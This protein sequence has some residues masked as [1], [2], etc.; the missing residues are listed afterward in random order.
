MES[1]L[2]LIMA[3]AE[4]WEK[5]SFSNRTSRTHFLILMA[6]HNLHREENKDLKK[7]HNSLDPKRRRRHLEIMGQGVPEDINIQ[8]MERQ[9]KALVDKEW[10]EHIAEVAAAVAAAAAAHAPGADAPADE[11]ADPEAAGD[12]PDE[13]AD[14]EA[15]GDHADSEED[16]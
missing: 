2:W 6:I 16:R 11:A 3:K 4:P 10:M 13:A 15:A 8:E 1:Y 12:H 9:E 7:F 14:P 5:H